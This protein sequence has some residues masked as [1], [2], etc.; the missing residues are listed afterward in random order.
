VANDLEPLYALIKQFEGLYLLPYY[1]PAGILTVGY[2][3]TGRGVYPGV[4]WTKEQCEARMI[5]DVQK[6]VLG[7]LKLCPVLSQYDNRLCAISDFA[8]NCGLG[9]LQA[10]TLRKRINAE[11]WPGAKY[12]LMRWTKGGGRVLPGLVKRRMAECSLTDK[13]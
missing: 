10:S 2:G 4:K 5:S 7:T 1:C 9:N 11:D 8:Y 3:T 6:F 13:T 12:E